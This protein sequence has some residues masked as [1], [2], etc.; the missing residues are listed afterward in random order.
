[1]GCKVDLE[2]LQRSVSCRFR[3]KAIVMQMQMQMQQG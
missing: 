2:P 3:K 1:M